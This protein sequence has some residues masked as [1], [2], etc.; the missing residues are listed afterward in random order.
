M[1]C[2][3][4]ANQIVEYE[5]E[6]ERPTSKME[7][8]T[9]D[10]RTKYFLFFGNRNTLNSKTKNPHLRWKGLL[11]STKVGQLIWSVT[12]PFRHLRCV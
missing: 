9:N 5:A 1:T 12:I 3:I 6:L 10:K 4:T 7:T 2:F 11:Q 8:Y